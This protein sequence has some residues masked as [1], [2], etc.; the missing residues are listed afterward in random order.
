MDRK[1]LD[2]RMTNTPGPAAPGRRGFFVNPSGYLESITDAAQRETVSEKQARRAS[3]VYRLYANGDSDFANLKDAMSSVPT[4][5][6]IQIFGAYE[7]SLDGGGF[8][9]PAK[10]LT[11][12]TPGGSTL[13]FADAD[14]HMR[15]E[16]GTVLNL[17]HFNTKQFGTSRVRFVLNNA[18]SLQANFSII[19]NTVSYVSSVIQVNNFN[20]VVY[21]FQCSVI[22]AN[23]GI[24]FN[25]VSAN[26]M[27]ISSYFGGGL[28]GAYSDVSWS[29]APF[30]GCLFT[31]DITGISIDTTPSPEGSCFAI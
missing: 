26:S 7:E 1:R 25:A 10:T 30:Y 5:S 29:Q 17:M 14:D 20:D 31:N 28:N 9:V 21:M 12:S 23:Y 13:N 19:S 16:T 8:L 4:G 15:V 6:S 27:F 18:G 22:G 3:N 24:E 11:L 2:L